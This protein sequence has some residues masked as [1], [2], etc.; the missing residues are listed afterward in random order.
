MENVEYRPGPCEHVAYHRRNQSAKVNVALVRASQHTVGAPPGV[1]AASDPVVSGTTISTATRTAAMKDT[2][3]TIPAQAH[4]T[5]VPD[6][7]AV[8]MDTTAD[9]DVRTPDAARAPVCTCPDHDSP[10]VKFT[11][12]A[13]IEHLNIHASRFPNV[14]SDRRC[15]RVRLQ[16][17]SVRRARI[18]A[19][20]QSTPID[21][22]RTAGDFTERAPFENSTEERLSIVANRHIFSYLPPDDYLPYGDYRHCDKRPTLLNGGHDSM[23]PRSLPIRKNSWRRNDF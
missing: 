9:D 8:C 5:R 17:A 2:T 4:S 1:D 7:R 22:D 21:P 18:P 19:D 14:V 23:T 3:A 20:P 16:R 12:G 15:L 11:V 6:R 10:V 13:A